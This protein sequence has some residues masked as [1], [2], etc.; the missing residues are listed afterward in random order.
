MKFLCLVIPPG[1]SISIND[2]AIV[3]FVCLKKEVCLNS[4]EL[5]KLAAGGAWLD[6]CHVD[7]LL[8]HL[9]HDRLFSIKS[10]DMSISF[11]YHAQLIGD[12]WKFSGGKGLDR[13]HHIDTQREDRHIHPLFL[14]NQWVLLYMERKKLSCTVFDSLLASKTETQQKNELQ[15]IQHTVLPVFFK[16][17]ESSNFWTVQHFMNM[18]SQ[19]DNES[20]GIYILS[21]AEAIFKHS[22]GSLEIKPI[23]CPSETR[24]RWV[25]EVLRERSTERWRSILEK[26]PTPE[27]DMIALIHQVAKECDTNTC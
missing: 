9:R 27:A 13:F 10:T 8:Q 14:K 16:N 6:N 2:R 22:S 15:L 18:P 21:A 23:L 7:F 26:T 19:T 5:S 1:L 25:Q 20:C 24:K 4:Q 11:S 17:P 3:R 12:C